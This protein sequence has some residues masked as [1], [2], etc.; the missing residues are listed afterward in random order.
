L[1]FKAVIELSFLFIESLASIDKIKAK[2]RF[3]MIAH[4][5]I[6]IYPFSN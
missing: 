2:N 6:K 3:L 1:R 5:Y 4:I